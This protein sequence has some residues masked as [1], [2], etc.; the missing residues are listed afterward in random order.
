VRKTPSYAGVWLSKIFDGNVW[1]QSTPKR[2]EMVITFMKML[3]VGLPLL[4]TGIVQ[5]AICDV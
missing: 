4:Q 1:G 5:R 3:F 2:P